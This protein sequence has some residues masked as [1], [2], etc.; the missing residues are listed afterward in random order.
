MRR[1][2]AALVAAMLA[3]GCTGPPSGDADGD[4]TDDWSPSPTPAAFRPAAH[5]CHARLV[6]AASVA[7]EEPVGCDQVH[8]S[9]AFHLGTAPD[10]DVPP[11]AGTAGDRAAYRECAQAAV[12]FVGGSWRTARLA[13][14]VVWPTRQGWSGGARWFRC[15]LTQTDLDGYGQ[16]GRTGSLEGELTRP[17]PLRLGCFTPTVDGETVTEMRPVGCGQKHRAEFAGLWQAPDVSYADL[18]AGV[19]R[20]AAGCRS[21]IAHFAAL[22]DD[23]DMQYRSGWISYNPTRSEWVA[24][25]RRVR[26]FV[27]FAERTMTRSLKNAGPSVLTVD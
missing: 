1:V 13:V 22:P 20:S 18:E 23:S 3:A 4:L 24:G 12:D 11:A 14:H 15:D 7:D 6:Q 9:E 16:S 27:Y 17:S 2:V 19:A 25:E 10:A 21:V 26:C 5:A 8:V